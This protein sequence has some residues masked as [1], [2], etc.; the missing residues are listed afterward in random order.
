MRSFALCMGMLLTMLPIMLC[1]GCGGSGTDVLTISPATPS[2]DLGATQQFTTRLNGQVYDQ[3]TWYVA[4]GHGTITPVGLY[5]APMATGSY[6]VTATST[7]DATN[8][9]STTVTVTD[10]STA[11]YAAFTAILQP[12]VQ[13][14][15][16]TFDASGCTDAEDNVSTLTVRW[17]WDGDGTYDTEA[18]TQ[19]TATH[20]YN[21]HGSYSVILLVTDSRGKTHTVSHT[22]TVPVIVA[23]PSA[24][25]TVNPGATYTFTPSV[26]NV[27]D[28]QVTWEVSGGSV[29]TAG[30]Y[31]APVVPGDYTVTATSVED[32]TASA[33]VS[34]HVPDTDVSVEIN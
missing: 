30:V 25:V 15:T 4:Q 8:S 19:K 9:V 6:I 29:T 24:L 17:D 28:Q 20:T 14:N 34:V 3:V 21:Q 13:Q 32:Q 2:I 26:Y 11:P 5:T 10:Q 31:T 18:A 23:F 12:G 33:G 16:F 1:T 27:A 7:V 22:V